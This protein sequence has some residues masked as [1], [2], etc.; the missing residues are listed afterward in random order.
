M[1]DSVYQVSS[2]ALTERRDDIVR[3]VW[4]A[5]L[6]AGAIVKSHGPV[7]GWTISVSRDA[8]GFTKPDPNAGVLDPEGDGLMHA[9]RPRSDPEQADGP[10]AALGEQLTAMLNVVELDQDV[11]PRQP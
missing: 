10:L 6:D 5:M 8:I 11:F 9:G 2:S 3:A 4:Q 1:S 7:E